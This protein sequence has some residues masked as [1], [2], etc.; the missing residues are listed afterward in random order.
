MIV[1]AELPLE[2][3][4]SKEHLTARL[5]A[6]EKLD[7]G[8]GWRCRYEIGEPIGCGRDIYGE[9][10]LQALSLAIKNL[11]SDLYGSDEYK[12]GRLGVAGEYGGYLG[13]PAPNVFLD[14]APYPF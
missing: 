13:I 11:S 3:A 7:D 14:Q 5:F 12:D 9:W 2:L 10:S 8:P 1:I 4:G 6:P